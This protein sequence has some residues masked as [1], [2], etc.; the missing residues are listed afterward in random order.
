MARPG[1]YLLYTTP[2]ADLVS[3]GYT[4]TKGRDLVSSTSAVAAEP[5]HRP[6]PIAKVTVGLGITS[7]E[8]DSGGDSNKCCNY[9]C[10]PCLAT[11]DR[12]WIF[13]DGI[14]DVGSFGLLKAPVPSPS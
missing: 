11:L 1:T 4:K 2:Y 8:L 9:F 14:F 5:D 10:T 12:T 6:I 3:F 7:S 13:L